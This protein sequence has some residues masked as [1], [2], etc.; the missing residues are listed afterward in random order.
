MQVLALVSDP[1]TVVGQVKGR[2]GP[3]RKA[4]EDCFAAGRSFRGAV[5]KGERLGDRL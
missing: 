2:Q 1:G 3:T 5:K 4:S